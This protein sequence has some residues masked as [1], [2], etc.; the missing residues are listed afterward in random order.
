MKVAIIAVSIIPPSRMAVVGVFGNTMES[1][2]NI[3]I[4]PIAIIFM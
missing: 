2:R 3:G 1:I 4:S